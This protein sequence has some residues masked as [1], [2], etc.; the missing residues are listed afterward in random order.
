MSKGVKQLFWFKLLTVSAVLLF[1]LSGWASAESGTTYDYPIEDP[2]LATVA[3]S[4]L[5]EDSKGP[6]IRERVTGIEVFKKKNLPPTMRNLGE[7]KFSVAWQPREAPLVFIIPGTGST[8]K[9]GRV[10]AFQKI[11]HNAGYHVIALNSTFTRRFAAMGSG[12]NIPGISADDARDLYEV[13]K[14]AYEKV[15]DQVKVREFY[16]TGY[17]L[18]GL[19]AGFVSKLD[20]NEGYF[21]FEK[22]LLINPPVNLYTS[23]AILDDYVTRNLK[24]RADIFFDSIFEKASRYFQ[25]KGDVYIDEEF[26][27]DINRIAPLTQAELEGLIG[28]SFRL[29][30]ASLLFSVDI[31]ENGGHLKARDKV[32]TTGT[33]TTPY[34]KKALHWTFEDYLDRVLLPHALKKDPHESKVTLIDKISLTALGPYLKGAGKIAVVHNRDDIILGKGDMAFLTDTFGE[35]AMIWPRGGHL[36]NMLHSRNVDHMLDFFKK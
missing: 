20:E 10:M 5:D 3:G 34:F 27:Y 4:P 23:T 6:I 36:G 1:C 16:L 22:V 25:Y 9:S 17:S 12:S 7:Y 15:K 14:G 19:T 11:L 35:R 26:L 30:L 21:N 8:Y 31:L 24:E 33:S 2:V 29:T 13:M 18:G 32:I 28:V